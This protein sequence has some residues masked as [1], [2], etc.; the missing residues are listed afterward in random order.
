MFKETEWSHFY[1]DL[2]YPPLVNIHTTLYGALCESVN[3]H[4][5]R[6][7]LVY[8]S[9][10]Y[11]Y[12]ELK[13][14]I[15]RAA[16]FLLNLGV[17][18]GDKIII[19][20]GGLPSVNI[21]IYASNAIGAVP[22]LFCGD[23]KTQIFKEYATYD[24]FKYLI[25]AD[26]QLLNYAPV[27]SDTTITDIVVAAPND[28]ISKPAIL[29]AHMKGF[30]KKFYR[31]ADI[32]SV[33]ADKK[34]HYW[35]EVN[36]T[37]IDSELVSKCSMN[38]SEHDPALTF[39]LSGNFKNRRFTTYDSNSILEHANLTGF[40]FGDTTDESKVM[41][42][43]NYVD[44]MYAAGFIF[45]TNSVLLHGHTLC[46]KCWGDNVDNVAQISYYEPDIVFAF[47]TTLNEIAGRE[48]IRFSKF[49]CI[50]RLIVYG[51]PL[52]GTEYNRYVSFF[53]RYA[54]G[55][56]IDKV[57]GVV[58]TASVFVYNPPELENSRILGIPLP[59]IRI[60][61]FDDDANELPLGHQGRICIS[62]PASAMVS[63][64]DGTNLLK[65]QLRD[66]RTWVFTGTLGHIDENR[67]VYF[68]GSITRKIDINGRYFYPYLLENE[69]L[70]VN[71]VKDCLVFVSKDEHKIIAAV[72]PEEEFLFDN[73][74]LLKL[75]DDVELQTEL[76]YKE[77][78]RQNEIEFLAS[79]PKT[80]R[81]DND[82]A[83]F[84]VQYE[85]RISTPLDDILEGDL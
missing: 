1:K 45:G 67:Y 51:F 30:V 50:K 37:T 62:T 66:E 65:R 54:P 4:P 80:K 9:R 20:A 16:T 55:V 31:A 43:L 58:E 82:Y 28:F 2:K 83:A 71:G 13:T 78:M 56:R 29:M 33:P 47:T 52:N 76:A 61:I 15:D 75:K 27:L 7:A 23:Y 19:C 60:K 59:G 22:S 21:M 81:G 18:K 32:S 35:K 3:K 34:I 12:L 68:D 84:E 49:K 79:L 44:L 38:V 85:E 11:N 69:I 72:V 46:L 48:S 36:E 63:D 24:D 64:E 40:L 42:Y 77:D 74:L 70:Q 8:A 26:K 53:E 17:K 10:T 57:Y 14:E 25:L 41:K 5:S 39:L 6:A 73:D